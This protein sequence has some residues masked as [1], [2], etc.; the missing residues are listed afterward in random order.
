MYLGSNFSSAN[1]TR[2]N[3]LIQRLKPPCGSTSLAKQNRSIDLSTG[4]LVAILN[5]V[6]IIM[7]AKIQRNMK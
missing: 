2:N 3:I 4:A 5:I 6:E 7:I 1:L